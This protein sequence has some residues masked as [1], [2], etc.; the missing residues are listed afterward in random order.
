MLKLSRAHSEKVAKLPASEN[1]K[2]SDF[3]QRISTTLG[4]SAIIIG[5]TK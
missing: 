1:E 2:Y 3:V 4:A 5:V